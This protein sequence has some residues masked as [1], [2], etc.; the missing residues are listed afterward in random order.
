MKEPIPLGFPE[1]FLASLLLLLNG[2]ISLRL[3]LGLGRRLVVA[4][5]R[6]VVQLLLLGYVL[7]PVFALRH[8]L[9][10]A[11]LGVG[12]IVLAGFEA[13]KRTGTSFKGMRASAILAMLVAAGTT[14]LFATTIVL[15]AHPWWHPQYLVPLLGMILGNGLNGVSLGFE[16]CLNR[17]KEGRAEVE[18][19]LAMGATQWEASRGIAAEALRTGMTP[20][21]NAMSVVGLITIPGM[22]TGQLLAG[23]PPQQAARYQIL[24]MFLIAGAVAMGTTIAVWLSIRRLFDD[25]HRLRLERLEDRGGA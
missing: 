25:Q 4:A 17:L 18:F 15:R 8:P 7:L 11:V 14:T 9:P 24:I 5:L 21:L 6:T 2:L 22:M 10:V 13:T 12:M 19:L 16:R 1:L 23:A 20:I 3:G